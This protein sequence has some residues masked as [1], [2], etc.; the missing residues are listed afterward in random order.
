MIFSCK[1]SAS[2]ICSGY[3]TLSLENAQIPGSLSVSPPGAR[4]TNGISCYE[5]G[6]YKISSNLKVDR[7]IVSGT[8][9]MNAY[10]TTC[11][12]VRMDLMM[13][14]ASSDIG[15]NINHDCD[16]NSIKYRSTN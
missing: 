12:H 2:C 4:S 5:K 13:T 3:V 16:R 1:N 9:A 6:H 10:T 15:H 14:Y 7:N 8:G 11:S